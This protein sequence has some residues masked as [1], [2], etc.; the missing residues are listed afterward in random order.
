MT[1]VLIISI[2]IIFVVMLLAVL[3]TSK[4]YSFKHSVDPLEE[5]PHINQAENEKSEDVRNKN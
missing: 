4:A 5:N 1:T 2:I 3:T